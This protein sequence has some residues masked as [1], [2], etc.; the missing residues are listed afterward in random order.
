MRAL[1]WVTGGVVRWLLLLSLLAPK[2]VQAITQGR[3]YIDV[4]RLVGD[5]SIAELAESLDDREDSRVL[6]E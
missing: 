3:C 2:I 4:S 1:P 5:G 6:P